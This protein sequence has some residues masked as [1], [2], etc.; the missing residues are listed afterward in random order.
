MKYSLFGR[1]LASAAA[2]ALAFPSYAQ[3]RHI[4]LEPGAFE[5]VSAEGS[6]VVSIVEGDSYLVSMDV[7]EEFSEFMVA[8]IVD[9]VLVLNVDEKKDLSEIWKKFRGRNAPSPVF[10]AVV[11]MPRAALK[12]LSLG[13][14][15]ALDSLGDVLDSAA[16]SLSIK[17]NASAAGLSVRSSSVSLTLSKK[18]GADLSVVCDTVRVTASGSSDLRLGCSATS[19][20]ELDLG[21]NASL[22]FVGECGRISMVSNGTSKAILNGSAPYALYRIGGSSSVNALNLKVKDANIDMSGIC[23]LKQAASEWL[24]VSIRNGASLTY[25]GDPQFKIAGIRNASITRYREEKK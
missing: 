3:L 14:G 19:L 22:V 20:V 25:D 5:G 13:G 15:A 2:F 8:D 10:R 16:V 21:S 18:A 4:D 23:S 7:S 12:T 24:F 6:F 1:I 17:D 9:S 11:T